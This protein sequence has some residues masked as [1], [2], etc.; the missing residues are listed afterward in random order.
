MRNVRNIKNVKKI[1]VMFLLTTM[2]VLAGCSMPETGKKKTSSDSGSEDRITI[3]GD[4]IHNSDTGTGG[5]VYDRG[6]VTVQLLRQEKESL[7]F[8]VTNNSGRTVTV[9]DVYI[10][11][12]GETT[13]ENFSSGELADGETGETEMYVA[14]NTGSIT[15]RLYQYDAEY[16]DVKGSMSDPITITF[17]SKVSLS[18]KHLYSKLIDNENITL[19]FKRVQYI[20]N[21]CNVRV[22]IYVRNKTD[23]DVV[24]MTSEEECSHPDYRAGFR[25]ILPAGSE[26]EMLVLA[27]SSNN[28]L[29]G[30]ELDS[31]SMQVDAYSLEDYFEGK[32]DLKQIFQV[33]RITIDLP[34]EGRPERVIPETI[35]EEEPVSD[36]VSRQREE[37]HIYELPDAAANSGAVYED[38]NFRA[39]Y[40]Y[41]DAV[42]NGDGST[43]IS[44]WC[45]CTNKTDKPVSI[46]DDCRVNGYDVDC[47]SRDSI[48]AM[49]Q[50]YIS[51][52]TDVP[53][54]IGSFSFSEI[55][56]KVYY[57][58]GVHNEDSLVC[59]TD[60][61]K[62]KSPDVPDTLE[63]PKG[64]KQVYSDDKCE[65]YIMDR[66]LDNKT[67]TELLNAFMVNKTDKYILTALTVKEKQPFT[68]AG[69]LSAYGGSSGAGYLRLL[70]YDD[71]SKIPDDLSGIKVDV[72]AIEQDGSFVT[73]GEGAL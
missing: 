69:H 21:R 28:T 46:I 15:M 49:T 13:D 26:S 27:Y 31:I 1:I 36:F 23:K 70:A 22:F 5:T 7:V 8:S 43:N 10:M 41:G 52:D 55:V 4:G 48:G 44:M 24:L 45:L 32:D 37:D 30:S 2:L 39:E 72:S 16:N 19:G 65:V 12:D 58:T 51:V 62:I 63:V 14:E 3:K 71:D 50:R 64:A 38:D 33:G 59:E 29:N 73:G 67:N 47:Y 6:G 54:S 60:V 34:R 61:M 53:D 40:V 68:I 25:Q 42:S 35:Q 20:P 17:H 11:A 66:S 56:M 18:Q 9:K 57:D